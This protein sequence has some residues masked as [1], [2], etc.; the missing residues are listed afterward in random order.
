[1]RLC[2]HGQLPLHLHS[3]LQRRRTRSCGPASVAWQR[4]SGPVFHV[5]MPSSLTIITIFI[6]IIIIIFFFF[7][8]WMTGRKTPVYLLT[9][10][11]LLR[12]S[13]QTCPQ[14]SSLM[15]LL[16][17]VVYSRSSL[18]LQS[19]W[20][21]SKKILTHGTDPLVLRW[22]T[23]TDWSDL[24]SQSR[25]DFKSTGEIHTATQIFSQSCYKSSA[26]RNPKRNQIFTIQVE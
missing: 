1:M 4:Y 11:L 17:L 25:V 19:F 10:L 21:T 15:V 18:E 7:S 23:C 9:L 8:H 3:P 5:I 12:R 16:K 6:V 20:T 24:H 13:T 14:K 26:K 2:G 22:S